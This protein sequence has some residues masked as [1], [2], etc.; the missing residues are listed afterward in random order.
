MDSSSANF[1]VLNDDGTMS[2]C[3]CTDDAEDAAF[4]FAAR[5]LLITGRVAARVMTTRTGDVYFLS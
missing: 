3:S 1:T 5:R 2:N 4:A